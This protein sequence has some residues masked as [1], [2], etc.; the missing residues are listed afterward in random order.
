LAFQHFRSFNKANK[1]LLRIFGAE[2]DSGRKK[3][4]LE[5]KKSL[6]VKALKSS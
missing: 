2:E 1:I 4:K 3:N 6:K 5:T